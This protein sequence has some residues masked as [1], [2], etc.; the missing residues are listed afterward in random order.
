MKIIRLRAH[1][2]QRGKIIIQLDTGQ[3]LV[4]SKSSIVSA[5]IA[6]NQELSEDQLHQLQKIAAQEHALDHALQYLASRPRSEQEIRQRL[7][8]AGISE[9][10]QEQTLTKLR[11]QGLVN[12]SSF[13][14]LWRE[15]RDRTN[16]RGAQLLRYELRLKGLTNETI[17]SALPT[18]EEESE[19]A[20]RLLARAL[21]H[22][23]GHTWHDFQTQFFPYL[24]RRG[25]SSDIISQALRTAWQE[26]HEK[27]ASSD[28]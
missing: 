5:N 10:E 1:P 19:L 26:L 28:H 13:A 2:H 24:Q 17:A 6:S 9:V 21:N 23:H 14:Q 12:D 18:P 16:P 3:Q 7:R 11:E 20:L 22:F 25:F 15:S 27:P 4:I 8:S